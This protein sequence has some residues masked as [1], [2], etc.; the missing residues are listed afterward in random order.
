MVTDVTNPTSLGDI[1]TGLSA[2]IEPSF[3]KFLF[4]DVKCQSQNKKFEYS[5]ICW[6]QATIV[7]KDEQ[8]FSSLEF[9][10]LHEQVKFPILFQ[11]ITRLSAWVM[12]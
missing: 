2:F 8:V 10:M 5:N 11:I 7:F 6:T 12:L 4:H 3:H 9:A 1:D